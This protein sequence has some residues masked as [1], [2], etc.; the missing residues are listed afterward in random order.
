MD[1]N[2]LKDQI[3]IDICGIIWITKE[4]LINKPPPFDS[5][6]YFLDGALITF[7][8]N[9]KKNLTQINGTNLFMAQSFGNSFFVAHFEQSTS[10]LI[11]QISQIKALIPVTNK[12]KLVLLIEPT[13]SDLIKKLTTVFNPII[14]KKYNVYTKEDFLGK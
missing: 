7:Y 11:E 3:S 9:H 8:N 14:L 13:G 10:N 5:L 1:L 2:Q 12:E 4:N 6:D